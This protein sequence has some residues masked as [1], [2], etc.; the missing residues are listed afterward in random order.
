[1]SDY[2]TLA[3]GILLAGFGGEFFLRGLLGLSGW[4]RVSPGIIGATVAAF[5]TSS[6]ELSVAITSASVG[7]PEISLGDALGSNVVNVAFILGLALVIAGIACPRDSV[8]RDFPGALLVPLIVGTLAWDGALSRIDGIVL[9]LIFAAWMVVVIR[10]VRQQRSTA[11]VNAGK[12]PA[13]LVL[14]ASVAG[15]IG[16]FGGGRLI[17]LG[18]KGI[19]LKFG[20]PE[21]IIG[22]TVIAIGTSVPELAT[23]VMAQIRGHC[24]MGLGTILGS[25]IFNGLFIVGLAATICPISTAGRELIITLTAGLLTTVAT[26]PARDGCIGRMRGL[27]LLGAYGIYMAALI[28]R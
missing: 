19:A 12:R 17:V 24:E 3:A 8:R 28:R 7:R 20:I 26:F 18:A 6:P 5:A 21:F 1:M 16:L 27:F 10:D 14:A 9:L 13:I 23:T 22:A 15:L 4:L 25:N 2:V 11:E